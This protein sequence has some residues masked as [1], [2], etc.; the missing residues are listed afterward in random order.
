MDKQGNKTG[1]RKKGSLNKLTK[2]VKR[3]FSVAFDGLQDDP[4]KK[5]LE[6]GKQ[7]PTEF[8]KLVARFVP[9]ALEHSGRDG[10]PIETVDKSQ[11]TI[12]RLKMLQDAK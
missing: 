3:A 10:G 4:E 8:Y 1:G 11:E 12:D 9:T 6:W 5:L 7:N 2:K